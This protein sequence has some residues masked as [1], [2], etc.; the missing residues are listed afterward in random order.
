MKILMQY[1]SDFGNFS[2][3]DPE[4]L[5]QALF[6]DTD[7]CG[8]NPDV[9]LW[10]SH[11]YLPQE[12][13]SNTFDSCTYFSELGID[14]MQRLI[15]ETHKRGM[16]A[17]WH[18]R[19][20]EVDFGP[21]NAFRKV[22]AEN[23][24]KK[25]HP[26][27]LIRTWYEPGLWNLTVPALQDFKIAYIRKFANKYNF[28][29]MCIDF[30]RHLPCLPPGAQWEHRDAVTEFMQKVRSVIP[31]GMK[32]GAKVPEN[33]AACRVDGFDVEQ[34]VKNGSVDFFVAGSR[35]ISSDVAWY[36]SIT[37]GTGIEV[38][39]CWDPGTPPTPAT[40]VRMISTAVCLPTGEPKK[41]TG[42]L[43]SITSIP[44]QKF[45]LI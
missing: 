7:K 6:Y 22:P 44:L 42:L 16:K 26:D 37:A 13:E 28:D 25:E 27:W 24:V 43:A 15:D 38:Y 41:R 30:L 18:H 40:G 29:G 5:V 4:K 36:K 11:S 39:P 31:A 10:E 1:D 20:C 17:Y 2:G 21:G 14:M 3:C 33:A 34:W 12:C 45:R 8:E 32:L 23:T 9:I 19:F 35:S